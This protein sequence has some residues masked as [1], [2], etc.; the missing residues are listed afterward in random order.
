MKYMGKPKKECVG[1]SEGLML[2]L[3]VGLVVGLV[4]GLTNT[5]NDLHVFSTYDKSTEHIIL[6]KLVPQKVK[7]GKHEHLHNISSCII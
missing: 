3:T 4:V 5:K 2:S 7:G 6:R 1:C